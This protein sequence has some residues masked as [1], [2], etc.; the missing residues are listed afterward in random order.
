MIGTKNALFVHGADREAWARRFDI[1]ISKLDWCGN[2]GQALDL[3]P[4]AKGLLRGLA[5]TCDCGN[6][7]YCVVS[8]GPN[9]LLETLRK[10]TP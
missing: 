1:D 5:A 10:E 3:V 6:K 7:P 2:C 9:D 4:F 8:A